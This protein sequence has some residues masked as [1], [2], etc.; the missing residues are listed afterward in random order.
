M[1]KVPCPIAVT[2]IFPF[3]ER[4]TGGPAWAL[5]VGSGQVDQFIPK[6][7]R[8]AN[9]AL[10]CGPSPGMSCGLKKTLPLK[11]S[12]T[13]WFPSA[14]MAG[15]VPPWIT[16]KRKAN[17][18]RTQSGLKMFLFRVRALTKSRFDNMYISSILNGLAGLLLREKLSKVNAIAYVHRL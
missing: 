4:R 11:W 15:P 8:R 18:A 10:R 14:L 17:S 3:E 7:N 13:S 12:E 6:M 9:K 5:P 1:R 2:I 16:S